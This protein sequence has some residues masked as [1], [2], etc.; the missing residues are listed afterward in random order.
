VLGGALASVLLV[1]R[2]RSAFHCWLALCCYGYLLYLVLVFSS[3]QRLTVGWYA[4]RFFEQFAATI[5]LGA[6]LFEVFRLQ[7]RLQSSYSQAYETS[8]RDSLTGLFRAATD[9]ALTRSA[10]ARRS[11]RVRL[12]C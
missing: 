1:T 10:S 8:I 5:M 7:K 11:W 12:R 2:L 4:S 9:N 6:L 3:S